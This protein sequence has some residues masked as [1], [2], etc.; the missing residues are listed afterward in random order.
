MYNIY[1]Q[2]WPIGA[3]VL[4]ISALQKEGQVHSMSKNNDVLLVPPSNS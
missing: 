3:K 4:Y 2:K 1:A